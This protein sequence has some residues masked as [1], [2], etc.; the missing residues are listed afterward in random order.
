MSIEYT[1]VD[2]SEKLIAIAK[3]SY[4]DADYKFLTGDILKLSEFSQINFDYVFCVAVLQ[5]IPGREL[6]VAALR[7]LKNKI[8]DDGKIIVSTWNLWEQRKYR[9]LIYKFALLKLIKKNK[10]DFGDIV[11]DGFNQRSKRYYHAFR[12]G[13]LKR[14]VK[15]A[16]LKIDKIYKD[17]Y[18]YYAILKK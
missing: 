2:S 12:K 6:Q 8:K 3:N 14:I 11:F 18:N 1:G 4:R 5:H 15:K 10:M 9:K 17:K 16:G 7:Q 13:E